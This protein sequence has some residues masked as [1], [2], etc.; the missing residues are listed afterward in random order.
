MKFFNDSSIKTKLQVV[1]L[2]VAL[3]T[4]ALIYIGFY[5]YEQIAF[6]KV[7]VNNL[8]TR[9]EIVAPEI[10]KALSDKDT[11]AVKQILGNFK[12]QIN[13]ISAAVYDANAKLIAA[14]IRENRTDAIPRYPQKPNWN[15]SGNRLTAFFLL[16]G[17]QTGTIYFCSDTESHVDRI[18]T[19]SQILIFIIL[20][21]VVLSYLSAEILL[22][23]ISTPITELTDTV[24]KILKTNDFSNRAKV[25]GRDEI[26]YL[27]GSF[28]NMLGFLHEHEE[29]LKKYKL[30]LEEL[31]KERTAQLEAVNQELESFS[32]SVSH[33]LRAPLRH[34]NGFTD[35]LRKNSACS[36]DEK[37][38]Y[39]LNVIS[40]ASKQMGMLIDDLLVFSRIG[41]T[42]IKFVPVNLNN[43]IN[44][45]ISK[46]SGETEGRNIVWE[47]GTLPVI[48]ADPTL[49]CLVFQNLVG[50]ALKYTRTRENTVIKI[51]SQ[52]TDTEYIF[53]IKDNGVGFDMRYSDRLF[54]VF[55]RLHSSTEFE[56]TG[57]GLANVHRIITRHGGRIW[58]SGEV[59][60][61]ATFYFTIPKNNN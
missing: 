20:I 42:Q 14:Y 3:L 18:Q 49:F 8:K 39:Y 29:D 48:S 23:K 2:S 45:A 52:H 21:S 10:Q 59:D 17:G 25:S 11:V 5:S 22:K 61:G 43:I 32:Y 37:G 51:T 16:N 38:T 34:I 41:K 28:N 36:L 55:Q 56:G 35:L 47:I 4:C 7:F 1:I 54:G 57:I 26:G 46:L 53:S 9:A 13:L 12:I 33:D 58:A 50:N 6:R 40:D 19:Y 44:E 30:H 24:R 60:K 15:F 31:V 27:A